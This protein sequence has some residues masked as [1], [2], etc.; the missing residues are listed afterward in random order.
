MVITEHFPSQ[1]LTSIY[2]TYLMKYTVVML[3]LLK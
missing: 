3:F 2:L 1:N